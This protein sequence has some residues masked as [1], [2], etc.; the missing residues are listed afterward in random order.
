VPE[1][2]F[3]ELRAIDYSKGNRPAHCKPGRK[4]KP[5]IIP[6]IVQNNVVLL[7]SIAFIN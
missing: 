6:F 3:E 1:F 4:M 2:S 5:A 7:V